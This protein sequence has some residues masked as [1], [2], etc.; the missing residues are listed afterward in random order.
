MCKFQSSVALCMTRRYAHVD[1]LL[2]KKD[3]PTQR[4]GSMF[5]HDVRLP[6]DPSPR[7][8]VTIRRLLALAHERCFPVQ[9]KINDHACCGPDELPA[10]QH[11]PGAIVA[12]REEKQ[13]LHG[14]DI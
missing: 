2:A 14:R 11:P 10:V 6:E 5:V 9:A 4:R 3:W 1:V 13:S 12:L 7:L 8:D